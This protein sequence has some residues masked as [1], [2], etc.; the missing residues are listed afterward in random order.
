MTPI[1]QVLFLDAQCARE[2][3]CP[4]CDGCVYPPSYYCI[5]CERGGYDDFD[6]TEPVL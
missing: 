2:R 3:R 4:R 6:G 1:E 5:Y